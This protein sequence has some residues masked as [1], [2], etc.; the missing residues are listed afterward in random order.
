MNVSVNWWVSG[1]QVSAVC[2]PWLESEMNWSYVQCCH[3][4]LSVW[5]VTGGGGYSRQ[6]RQFQTQ[7]TNKQN[8]KIKADEAPQLGTDRRTDHYKNDGWGGSLLACMIFFM[9]YA[10]HDFNSKHLKY[11]FLPSCLYEFR[12]L[13]YFALNEFLSPLP[14]SPPPSPPPPSLL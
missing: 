11:S 1:S 9:A 14:L 5:F 2:S 7:T 10:L 6:G 8:K 3:L 4:A 13:S 12:F